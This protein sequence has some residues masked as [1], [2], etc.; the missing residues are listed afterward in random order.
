MIGTLIDNLSLT[1]ALLLIGLVGI[2]VKTLMEGKGWTRSSKLLR[3][4]NADLIARNHTLEEDRNDRIA[5]EITLNSRIDALE[6]KVRDLES[7]DQAAVLQALRDH[8]LGAINRA[9]ETHR[10]L[11]ESTV[12]LVRIAVSLENDKL[13]GGENS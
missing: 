3:E 4:E 6:A 8:E 9:E 12:Q 11:Q 10:L 13:E 1:D 2:T 7:R 5:T